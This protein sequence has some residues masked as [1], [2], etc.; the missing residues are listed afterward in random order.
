MLCTPTIR[1]L[2]AFKSKLSFNN[3]LQAVYVRKFNFPLIGALSPS[4]GFTSTY[5]LAV[6]LNLNLNRGGT[7]IIINQ[8]NTL[9]PL[10]RCFVGYPEY[11]VFLRNGNR[12]NNNVLYAIPHA[13]GSMGAAENSHY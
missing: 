5:R 6:N 3:V 11:R 10:A 9:E 13:L 2:S 12:N 7:A 1:S 4:A 8:R